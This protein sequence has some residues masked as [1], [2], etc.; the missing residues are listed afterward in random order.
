MTILPIVKH[1]NDVLRTICAPV[2]TV[3]DAVRKL[4]DD[5]LDTM[6]DAPGIGL[7]ACQVGITQRIVVL[8]CIRDAEEDE[9]QPMFFINPEITWV[10]EEQA[11]YEEGCLSIPGIYENVTRPAECK[12]TFLDYNGQAQ[13]M[14]CTELLATCIQHEVDH[15]NGVLFI[16]HISRLKRGIAMKKYKKLKSE[17]M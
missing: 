13:E 3:D 12:V 2:A 8:D 9:K 16:D 10:S 15:L 6:Y 4:M 7:A 11:E 5:M 14:H 1:I 17:T